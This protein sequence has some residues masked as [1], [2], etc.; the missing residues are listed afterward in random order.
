MMATVGLKM[1]SLKATTL[2]TNLSKHMQQRF[3]LFQIE[4]WRKGALL[5]RCA[6][7][8]THLSSSQVSQTLTPF[9]YELSYSCEEIA[10]RDTVK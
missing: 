1:N 7:T 5:F 9:P 6:K 8:R 4:A 2:Q 3:P 10:N